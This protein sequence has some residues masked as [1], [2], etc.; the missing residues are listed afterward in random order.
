VCVGL[1]QANRRI[2][3][4]ENE[5]GRTQDTSHTHT[6]ETSHTHAQET[7]LSF[8][9][10]SE[11]MLEQKSQEKHGEEGEEEV[12]TSL[13]SAVEEKVET[14]ITTVVPAAQQPEAALSA[15]ANEGRLAGQTEKVYAHANGGSLVSHLVRGH[16]QVQAQQLECA[17]RLYI[18]HPGLVLAPFSQTAMT[19]VGGGG[20]KFMG[21]TADGVARESSG[22]MMV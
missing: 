6:Q 21:K 14:P 1:E 7:S 2:E 10:T 5:M 11:F 22:V 20:L 16:A 3:K 13:T 19:S 15:W 18:E 4:F 8:S 9:T 17:E 12:E